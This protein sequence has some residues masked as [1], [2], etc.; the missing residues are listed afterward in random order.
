MAAGL[1]EEMPFSI[2]YLSQRDVSLKGEAL[3]LREGRDRH[4]LGR[5]QEPRTCPG[6]GES[7]E[8]VPDRIQGESGRFLMVSYPWTKACRE[9]G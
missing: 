7:P 8:D 9:G 1:F 4:R 2:T 3:S 5:K 6:R